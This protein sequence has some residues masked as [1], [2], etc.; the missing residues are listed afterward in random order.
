MVKT[1]LIENLLTRLK[2][3]AKAGCELKSSDFSDNDTL[4]VDAAHDAILY[5][6][7][8][9][10]NDDTIFDDKH[11]QGDDT[12]KN[13]NYPGTSRHKSECVSKLEE[14][15]CYIRDSFSGVALKGYNNYLDS[16]GTPKKEEWHKY[17]FGKSMGTSGE[18]GPT[19]ESVIK[20]G[21]LLINIKKYSKFLN[22]DNFIH[23]A[24]N[25]AGDDN[26]ISNFDE[27]CILGLNFTWQAV[28]YYGYRQFLENNLNCNDESYENNAKKIIE[29][30]RQINFTTLEDSVPKWKIGH[31]TSDDTMFDAFNVRIRF[32]NIKS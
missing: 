17:H 19:E 21:D 1:E 9:K 27:H 4:N 2:K 7:Q 28:L 30:L 24:Y 32:I 8:H 12:K 31:P 26:D 3:D 10:H 25:L 11:Y 6:Q 14:N 18:I 13:S 23:T 29:C 15:V 20:N 22:Y 16:A 5:C